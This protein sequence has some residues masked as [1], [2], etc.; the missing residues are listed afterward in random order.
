VPAG[1]RDSYSAT[2]REMSIPLP[3][4]GQR[5]RLTRFLSF[6]TYISLMRRPDV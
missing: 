5:E 3:T 2:S 6:V 4:N 1:K